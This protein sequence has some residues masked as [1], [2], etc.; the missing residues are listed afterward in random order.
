[1]PN[2]EELNKMTDEQLI[3]FIFMQRQDGPVGSALAQMNRDMAKA[4][5]DSRFARVTQQQNQSTTR[6]TIFIIILNI[7]LVCL[8]GVLVWL[9]IILLRK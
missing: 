1:M 3:N 7:V 6:L 8:T 2:P 9:T 4:V 5:L